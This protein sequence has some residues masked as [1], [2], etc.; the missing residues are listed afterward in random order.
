MSKVR[1]YNLEHKDRG[2]MITESPD[3][4]LTVGDIRDAIANYPDDAEIIFGT[5]DHGEALQFLRFK[6][7]GER[8]LAIEFG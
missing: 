5:C 4:V 1:N 7:R 3:G 8:T 6:Q 2:T